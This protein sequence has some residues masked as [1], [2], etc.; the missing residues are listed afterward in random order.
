MNYDETESS[1]VAPDSWSAA[2]NSLNFDKAIGA[3]ESTAVNTMSGGNSVNSFFPRSDQVSEVSKQNQD[4]IHIF[5]QNAQYIGNKAFMYEDYLMLDDPDI[6]CINEHG[7]KANI[8]DKFVIHP[9]Y[10]IVS[11]FN[12]SSRKGGG[13]F[14]AVRKEIKIKCNDLFCKYSVERTCEIAA[15]TLLTG[16]PGVLLICLYRSPNGDLDEFFEILGDLMDEIS[17]GVRVILVGDFN[18][19]LNV[20]GN[21]KEKFMNILLRGNKLNQTIFTDTRVTEHSSTRID[22]LFTNIPVEKFQAGVVYNALSDHMG[23]E[24]KVEISGVCRQVKEN[25]KLSRR[26]DDVTLLTMKAN[27]FDKSL[28]LNSIDSD[29]WVCWFANIHESLFPC[30]ATKCKPSIFNSVSRKERKSHYLLLNKL[31]ERLRKIK[32]APEFEIEKYLEIKELIKEEKDSYKKSILH[33]RASHARNILSGSDNFSKSAWGIVNRH[34]ADKN[35]NTP[36]ET[37]VLDG[38]L[39]TD[40]YEIAES[41]NIFFTTR[42]ANQHHKIEKSDFDYIKQCQSVF[43]F[44][45]VYLESVINAIDKLKY[46]RSEGSDGLSNC[47]I[48][49]V[50]EEIAPTMTR[51]INRFFVDETFPSSLKTVKVTPLFKNGDRQQMNNYRPITVVSPISK[52]FEQIMSNQINSYLHL[53]NLLYKQQFGFRKGMNTEGAVRCCYEKLV[54]NG[55]YNVLVAIDLKKAFDSVNIDLLLIKLEI[56]G[57]SKSAVNCVRSYLKNRKQYVQVNKNA[58]KTKSG[59]REVNIGV[60]QGSN[61]GPL[62]FLLFINDLVPYLKLNIL[63]LIKSILNIILFADDILICLSGKS[64]EQLEIDIFII[65]NVLLQWCNL[66]LIEM[67]FVKTDFIIVKRGLRAF[68]P[69]NINFRVI[70][71]SI[72]IER[73]SSLKYLGLMCDDKLTFNDHVDIICGKVCSSLFLL[74]TLAKFCPI[75]ILLNVYHSMIMSHINY[76]ISVWSDCSNKQVERVFRLQKRALKIMFK[77]GRNESCKPVFKEHNLL[78][79]PSLIIFSQIRYYVQLVNS[80][81]FQVHEYNTR[82]AVDSAVLKSN[83]LC[84]KGHN[85]F[86]KLPN[87]VKQLKKQVGFQAATKSFLEKTA[88]YSFREFLEGSY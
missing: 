83:P 3:S 53:N 74:K 79:V 12:R 88:V 65:L 37:I 29:Q 75:S 39:I 20:E 55:N 25:T 71:D 61:I 70:I 11:S 58:E 63:K 36:V 44:N 5:F 1:R 10:K 40:H 52:V 62:F 38:K 86:N 35:N 4:Q 21:A 19:D 59:N 85:Y 60:A 77:L 76:C 6:L 49:S 28:E 41:F 80:S 81:N 13:S 50:K 48:K 7:L 87:H 84:I 69:T 22:N 46:K 18:I 16:G 23:I 51:L 34:R 56:L 31:N 27:I 57:F 66:N 32:I 9:D 54:S 43:N 17:T 42:I 72:E 24:F 15:C 68:N 82:G 33:R 64:L 67:N 73:V 45:P 8:V 30:K 47:F 78:T 26:Y 2:V 14:I